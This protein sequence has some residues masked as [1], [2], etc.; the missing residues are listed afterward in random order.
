MELS[1]EELMTIVTSMETPPSPLFDDGGVDDM[2]LMSAVINI[3]SPSSPLLTENDELS[4]S[5][6]TAVITG[7]IGQLSWQDVFDYF[8]EPILISDGEEEDNVD[9]VSISSDSDSDIIMPCVGAQAPRCWDLGLE[10]RSP[11]SKFTST[12]LLIKCMF[13]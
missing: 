8:N 9:A 11:K 1:D 10:N 12:P 13:D 5:I 4:D 2:E 3:E 7:E 6:E